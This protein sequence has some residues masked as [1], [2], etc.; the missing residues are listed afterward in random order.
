[1]GY[2]SNLSFIRKNP[3]V[4]AAALMTMVA[5]VA[6]TL[7]GPVTKVAPVGDKVLE[8]QTGSGASKGWCND[9]GQCS[10]SGSLTIDGVVIGTGSTTYYAGQGLSLNANNSFSL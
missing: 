4:I 3:G 7:R 1:M 5:G 8:L 2:T 6:L 9:L 10:F